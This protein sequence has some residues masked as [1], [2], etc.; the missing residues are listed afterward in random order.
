MHSLGGGIDVPMER[1]A[2]G[3]LSSVQPIHSFQ[4]AN[5]YAKGCAGVT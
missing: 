1:A 2:K 4:H 3:N 5:H